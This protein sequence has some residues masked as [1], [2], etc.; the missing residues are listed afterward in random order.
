MGGAAGGHFA[1]E[2]EGDP[3]RCV[4][5]ELREETGL[6]EKDLTDLQLRYV[7]RR[8]V[9]GEM[10]QNFYF[11]AG[12]EKDVPLDSTEGEL[13]WF[14]L[15][16][17]PALT[18]PPSAK[19]MMDHYLRT[20]RQNGLLYTGSMGEGGM[21]FAPVT[22]VENLSPAQKEAFYALAAEY[23]PDSE[24]ERMRSHEAGYAQAYLAVVEGG[25]VV[26]VAFGW[27]RWLE[28]AQ[29]RTFML[30]GIAVRGDCRRRGLG[31]ALLSALEAAAACYGAQG[32]SVGSAGGYVE[33]FY[34]ACGYTPKEYKVWTAC[35]PV[36]DKVF[37]SAQDYLQYD[38]PAADGFVVMEKMFTQKG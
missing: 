24:P 25:Q 14:P 12:L 16:A 31:R 33:A 4:L 18:M 36:V 23:L 19:G 15:E 27:P 28:D 8:M 34:M 10:R 35:G 7:T 26:G 29:D 37:A 1:Q 6:E 30:D 20:G 17:L 2:D 21:V 9:D 13:R 11:F 22:G 32:V 38:R 5:R 3:F